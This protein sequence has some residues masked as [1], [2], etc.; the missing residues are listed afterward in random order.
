MLPSDSSLLSALRMSSDSLLSLDT[1]PKSFV[2]FR[3]MMN[4]YG[5]MWLGN[6]N[7]LMLSTESH[8]SLK[9]FTH[10]ATEYEI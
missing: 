6:S 7:Q 5:K 2:K 1:L 4:K 3:R 10:S 9:D 8:N